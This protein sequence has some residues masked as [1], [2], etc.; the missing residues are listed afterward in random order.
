MRATRSHGTMVV[1]TLLLRR[2]RRMR[3]SWSPSAGA[4]GAANDRSSRAG[5]LS[6]RASVSTRVGLQRGRALAQRAVSTTSLYPSFG[7]GLRLL[8]SSPCGQSRHYSPVGILWLCS[9]GYCR[10]ILLGIPAL[11]ALRR[12]RH[13]RFERAATR[14]RGRSG[15]ARTGPLETPSSPTKASPAASSKRSWR[16]GHFPADR[17]DEPAASANSA[18][19]ANDRVRVRDLQGSSDSNATAPARSRTRSAHRTQTARLTP[20]LANHTSVTRRHLAA[21]AL[22]G[23]TTSRCPPGRSPGGHSSPGP[24]TR[25]R[26]GCRHRPARSRRGQSRGGA[27][28]AA[29]PGRAARSG[30]GSS[31]W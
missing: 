16:R 31:R 26:S 11:P 24:R 1:V 22:I 23:I 27:G 30:A 14:A 2:G 8:D 28:S 15:D 6:A 3:V 12:R 21:T 5:G 20:P 18:R 25:R 13:D 9:Y 19:S 10:C 29:G 4:F 17:K 7:D